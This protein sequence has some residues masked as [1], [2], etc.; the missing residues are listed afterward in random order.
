MAKCNNATSEMFYEV[1]G[2]LANVE[3]GLIV[4]VREMEKSAMVAHED[5]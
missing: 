1:A 4:G 3:K 2:R 5:N